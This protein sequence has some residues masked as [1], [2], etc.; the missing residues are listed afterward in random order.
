MPMIDEIHSQVDQDKKAELTFK[1]V[2]AENVKVSIKN[3]QGHYT[4]TISYLDRPNPFPQ[5][6][7]E[8]YSS[9]RHMLEDMTDLEKTSNQWSIE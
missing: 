7:P 5:G 8:L 3:E 2:D 6:R 9:W 4:R 1:N